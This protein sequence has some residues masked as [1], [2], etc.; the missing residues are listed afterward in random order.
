MDDRTGIIYGLVDPRNGVIRYVGL[1][2]QSLTSRLSK[3]LNDAKL[4]DRSRRALWVRDLVLIGARPFPVVL[5][6]APAE[7]LAE[8]E[9][10]WISKLRGTVGRLL[11]NITDGGEH[12]RMP[13][14]TRARMSEA[15]HGRWAEPGYRERMSAAL[16]RHWDDQD[17]RLAMSLRVR[18]RYQDPAEHAKASEAI[19]RS[20]EDH[21][22]RARRIE[23]LRRSSLDPEVSARRSA[24]HIGIKPDEQTRAKLRLA[25]SRQAPLTWEARARIGAALRGRRASEE[26]RARMSAAMKGQR[27]FLGHKH[28]AETKARM[29]AVQKGRPKGE[30][31]RAKMGAAMLGRGRG[32]TLTAEHRGKIRLGVLRRNA[33]RSEAR[34]LDATSRQAVSTHDETSQIP[35]N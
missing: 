8:A 1:T 6:R 16:R 11:T 2:T 17:K 34:A 29:S 32:R 20:W 26:A 14:S 22:V 12:P 21:V 33:E 27:R 23:G 19:R 15:M 24:A 28:S 18:R 25:R 9:V 31:T 35:T 4:G 7:R 3:H 30:K 13:P 5:E 10:R